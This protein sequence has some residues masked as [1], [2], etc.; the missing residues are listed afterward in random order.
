M[1]FCQWTML[2]SAII[3]IS[4]T[5]IE[6]EVNDTTDIQKSAFYLN[7]YNE[8]DDERVYYF[9]DRAQLL[10]QNYPDKVTLLLKSS[11]QNYTVV[12]TNW[13]TV[14]NIHFSNGNASFLFTLRIFFLSHRHKFYRV[15]ILNWNCLPFVLCP[16][17]PVSL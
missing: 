13:L 12:M 8:I 5:L 2:D 4:S 17:F 15:Y 7:S 10:T 1:L 11:L 16:L 3:C 14:A 9:L 6:L